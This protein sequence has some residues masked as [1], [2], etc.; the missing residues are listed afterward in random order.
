[1]LNKLKDVLKAMGIIEDGK[2]GLGLE[3]SAI[4]RKVGTRVHDFTVGDRVIVFK[5]GCF[6]TRMNVSSLLCAK[7]PDDISD[8]D[9]A[10]MPTV[11]ST[12][13]HSLM[14][15]GNLKKGQVSEYAIVYN[16]G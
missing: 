15:L 11:C 14:N 8:E 9:A 7:I 10:T 13:V 6:S 4:V 2:G 1:M 5:S 3:A 16:R 12:V